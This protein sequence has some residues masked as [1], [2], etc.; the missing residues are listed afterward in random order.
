MKTSAKKLIFSAL[1][2]AAVALQA[3][4]V[5]VL[6]AERQPQTAPWFGR[7]PRQHKTRAAMAAPAAQ[8]PA[9]DKV[10]APVP[11]LTQ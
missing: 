1:V 5:A 11:H 10:R 7:V 9:A 2:M 3:R 8:L 6:V 4:A